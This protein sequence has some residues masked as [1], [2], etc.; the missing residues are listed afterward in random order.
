MTKIKTDAEKAIA[1]KE[2]TGKKRKNKK[3]TIFRAKKIK[4]IKKT[5]TS[6]RKRK[7]VKISDE[8]TEK[9]DD[10]SSRLST[11]DNDENSVRM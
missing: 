4:T 8:K 11:N 9:E 2:K 7:R 3:S 10:V 6:S 5:A 1:T